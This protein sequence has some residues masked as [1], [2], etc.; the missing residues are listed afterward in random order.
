MINCLK[1]VHG[2][3]FDGNEVAQCA[4]LSFEIKKKTFRLLIMYYVKMYKIH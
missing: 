1:K 2:K 3:S 4:G